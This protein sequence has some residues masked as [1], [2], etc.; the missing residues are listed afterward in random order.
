MNGRRINNRNQLISVSAL[1]YRKLTRIRAGS[2]DYCVG[3]A[4]I[5]AR[6]FVEVADAGWRQRLE[7]VEARMSHSPEKEA[8]S[9]FR[10]RFGLRLPRSG[11]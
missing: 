6:A 1:P 4:E 2:Q 9:F 3:Q 5:L 7:F 10:N 11:I 8:R